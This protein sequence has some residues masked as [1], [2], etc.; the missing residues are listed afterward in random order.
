MNDKKTGSFYTP[1]KLIE[2]MLKHLNFKTITS[3]L[4][5]SVGD[6]RIIDQLIKKKG[7]LQVTC[8]DL[9]EEK[10]IQ[11]DKQYSE[12][13]NISCIHDDYIKYSFETKDKY[14]LIIG[15][16][17]YIN[18]NKL[19]NENID[20]SNKLLEELKLDSKMFKNIWVMFLVT[21]INLLK[22][23][24]KIFF[25]LPFEFLQVNYAKLLRNHLEKEFN[26][27]EIITF[28]EKIFK[29]VDQKICL[30]YLEK[31][32]TIPSIKYSVYKNIMSEIPVISTNI[33]RNKP[34]EKW[35]NAILTDKEIELLNFYIKKYPTLDLFG[36]IAPGIVT[37]ANNFFIVNKEFLSEHAIKEKSIQIISK[38]RDINNR[39]IFGEKEFDEIS[40][41]NKNV[42]LL[43]LGENKKSSF[44][45]KIVEYLEKGEKEEINKR[46]KCSRR[47]TWYNV[48]I[49][50]N[51]DLIFFKR[52]HLLPKFIINKAGCYTTDICYNLRVNHKFDKES[53]AFCFYNSLT[54][55]LCEYNGRFY[56]GGVCELTPSEF[57]KL[58]IPYK[59]IDAKYVKQ[60]NKMFEEKKK[61]NEIIDFVD[62]VVFSDIKNKKFL[63]DV[64]EIRD[65][66]ISR[67]IMT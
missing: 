21:S 34:L 57:K 41:E 23:N 15:N 30:V 5:P 52:Y 55:A 7:D 45:K 66:F 58:V 33:K 65:K 49:R 22:E 8:V 26:I 40:E 2:F 24:G 3:V 51:G 13:K 27:I 14:D 20:I 39:I 9:I 61:I 56:G 67:R 36:E 10:M 53:I 12:I 16:P 1:T 25:V 62:T 4:E 32:D 43:T 31:K 54:M 64:K 38:A 42:H 17:P 28:E 6:G 59:E 29:G 18:K 35:S 47:K 48:P 44:N 60:L 37:G 63:I 50:K 11:L 19:S 46:Y